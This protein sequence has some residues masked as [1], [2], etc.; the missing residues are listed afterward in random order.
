MKPQSDAEEEGLNRKLPPVTGAVVHHYLE[1]GFLAIIG[2]DPHICVPK[3]FR[4]DERMSLNLEERARVRQKIIKLSE[5]LLLVKNDE[6]KSQAINA[7]LKDCFCDVISRAK[8]GNGILVEQLLEFVTDAVAEL[9]NARGSFKVKIGACAESMVRFPVLLGTSPE[10]QSVV[11][12][13]LAELNLGKNPL[14]KL[15]PSNNSKSPEI[16]SLHSVSAMAYSVIG[17]IDNLKKMKAIRRPEMLSEELTKAGLSSELYE[18]I[19]A[20][21]PLTTRNWEKWHYVSVRF[22]KLRYGT[23]GNACQVS[24]PTTQFRAAFKAIANRIPST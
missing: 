7:L 24:N 4:P 16:A 20:L 9:Q 23:M 14:V 15:E 12:G 11:K 1:N 10:S 6:D 17:Y 8:D 21:K 2:D 18:E 5:T 22:L 19:I 3:Y 13:F